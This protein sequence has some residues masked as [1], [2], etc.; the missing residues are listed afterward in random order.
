MSKLVLPSVLSESTWFYKEYKTELEKYLGWKYVSYSTAT[1][2]DDYI[3][4]FVKGKIL[5]IK[6]SG[7]VYTEAGQVLGHLLEHGKLQDNVPNE[8]KVKF[9]VSKI[10]NPK[11]EFEK[12]VILEIAD[13]TIFI[14]FCDM[15]ETLEDGSLVITDLKTGAKDKKSYYSSEKYYQLVI[16]AYALSKMGYKI[17][18]I[19][20]EFVLRTGSHVK[21]P[22]VLEDDLTTIPLEF[23]EERVKYALKRLDC[24]VKKI[25]SLFKTWKKIENA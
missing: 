3:E 17:N 22:L 5:G 6:N 20:V 15:V 7:T 24:S 21:P 11:A 8:I 4:D 25:S 16:Y 14:G 1:S 13:D 18:S 2:V 12:L 19:K 23:N 10:R 9:D